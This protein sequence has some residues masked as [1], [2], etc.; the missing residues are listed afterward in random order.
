L[1]FIDC[2]DHTRTLGADKV[3]DV[4][5]FVDDLRDLNVTPHI[6]QNTTN[7]SSAIDAR[8]TRHPGYAISQQKRKQTEE[9]FGCSPGRC[10][11]ASRACGSNSF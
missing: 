10:C 7:R 11:A 3:Y 1:P 5:E 4:R 6:A 2:R 8:T 9:P